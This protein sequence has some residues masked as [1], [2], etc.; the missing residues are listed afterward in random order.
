MQCYLLTNI[1]IVG[2]LDPDSIWLD[3]FD[4]TIFHQVS[5]GIYFDLV[6]FQIILCLLIVCNS[7]NNN[8]LEAICDTLINKG[9]TKSAGLLKICMLMC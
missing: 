2:F 3:T 6:T 1:G 8:I 9:Y 5:T 7:I 4:W